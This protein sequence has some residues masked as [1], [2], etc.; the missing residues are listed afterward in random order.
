M[1]SESMSKFLGGAGAAL[2]VKVVTGLVIAAAAS[3]LATEVAIS[4]SANPAGWGRQVH[5]QVTSLPANGPAAG[6]PQPA[7]TLSNGAESG[8]TAG[9]G[10]SGLAGNDNTQGNPKVA[11]PNT[12]W[13]PE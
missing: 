13:V 10:Q 7:G 8:G 4:G 3:V 6:A 9:A 1:R 12:T 11:R 5:H 2:A